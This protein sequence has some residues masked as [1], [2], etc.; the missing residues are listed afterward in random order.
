MDTGYDFITPEFFNILFFKQNN[1]VVYPYVD[2]KHIHSLDSFTVGHDLIDI[3]STGLENMLDIVE[4]ETANSYS[5]Q[6]TFYYLLNVSAEDVEK[7][8]EYQNVRCIINTNDDV[9]H[10]VKGNKYIFYNKKNT[11][12]LNY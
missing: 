10:L 3:D 7:L 12:F 11:S 4:F 9:E 8:L 5:Q 1:L 6:P 2:V